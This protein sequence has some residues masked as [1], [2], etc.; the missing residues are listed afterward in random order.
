MSHLLLNIL[1]RGIIH[2]MYNAHSEL[3]NHE[4]LGIF[5]HKTIAMKSFVKYILKGKYLSA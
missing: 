5:L 2:I 4:G 1:N 3:K